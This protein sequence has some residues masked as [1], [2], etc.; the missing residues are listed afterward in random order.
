MFVFMATSCLVSKDQFSSLCKFTKNQPCQMTPVEDLAQSFMINNRKIFKRSFRTCCKLMHL[1]MALYGI[2]AFTW[3]RGDER[4]CASISM[5]AIQV[6]HFPQIY[7]SSV[8][9]PW[10]ANPCLSYLNWI[11]NSVSPILQTTLGPINYI[12]AINLLYE[13]QIQHKNEL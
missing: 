12:W 10:P 7:S 5:A 6:S 9:S 3:V 1:S 2:V 4:F 13:K 11:L 8:S